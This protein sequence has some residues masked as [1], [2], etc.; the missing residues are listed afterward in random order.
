MFSQKI[1]IMNKQKRVAEAIKQ[2]VSTMM[3]RVMVRV[4]NEDPFI[5]EE[6][7]AK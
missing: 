6:H 1:S 7:H 2:V 4:L 3:D 5:K